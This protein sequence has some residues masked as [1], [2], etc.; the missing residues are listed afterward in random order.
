[1][2]GT[3][4]QIDVWRQNILVD[5]DFGA[6]ALHDLDE[7]DHAQFVSVCHELVHDPSPVV[8]RV[9]LHLL[10]GSRGDSEDPV[11]EAAALDALNDPEQREFALGVLGRKGTP[12]A[13]PVLLAAAQRGEAE[14]VWAAARQARTAQ[15]REQVLEIARQRVLAEDS[16]TRARALLAIKRLAHPTAEQDLL[17]EVAQ[18][19]HDVSA[20]AL[21]R[22][23][24]PHVLPALYALLARLSP[25]DPFRSSVART[26]TFIEQG[27][28]HPSADDA[29]EVWR[30]RILADE[31]YGRGALEQLERENRQRFVELCRSLAGDVVS[32]VQRSALLL[33]ATNGEADDA[34]A[35]AV[36]IAD[37]HNPDLRDAAWRA[38][39]RVATPTVFPLLLAE[40]SAG[41]SEALHAAQA[42]AR[43]GE[44]RAQVLELARRKLLADDFLMRERAMEVIRAFS[45]SAAEEDL[46]VEALER[47]SDESFLEAICFATPRV[48]PRL[49]ELLKRIGSG[50]VESYGIARAIRIIQYRAG[51][52]FANLPG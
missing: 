40:A 19:F 46:L 31:E 28:R 12:Q 38:L 27:S 43:T 29:L 5:K 16:R 24:T 33:L 52:P 34:A 36:A 20:M 14:A 49:E 4:D 30:Q 51:G 26:I 17:L 11:T 32:T 6:Q 42:Q 39:G 41:S 21:L 25:T 45:T 23:A 15:Q 2:P 44:Q 50:Y 47:H 8:R 9:G 35:E 7:T 1:M 3:H 48:L 13:F 10:G 37:L 22:T 18:R